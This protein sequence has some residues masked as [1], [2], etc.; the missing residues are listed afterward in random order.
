MR[1]YLKQVI[2]RNT[3]RNEIYNVQRNAFCTII[4]VIILKRINVI[5]V[6]QKDAISLIKNKENCYMLK[7]NIE[8]KLW[9][10]LFCQW[11]I[12]GGAN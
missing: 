3:Q 6:G 10:I 9:F 12:T 7:S 5:Q 11:I 8:K 2:L 1:I 4:W